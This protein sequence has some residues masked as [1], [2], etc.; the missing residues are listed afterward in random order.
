M[1]EGRVLGLLWWS[2]RANGDDLLVNPDSY[3]KKVMDQFP[4]PCS[5]FLEIICVE[6]TI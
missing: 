3:L 6:I 4:V 1:G 5:R 2:C